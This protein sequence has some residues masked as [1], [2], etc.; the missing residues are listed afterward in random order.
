MDQIKRTSVLIV[1]VVQNIKLQFVFADQLAVKW[2]DLGSDGYHGRGESLQ[3]VDDF[4]KSFQ[5][6]VAVRSPH[7]TKKGQHQRSARE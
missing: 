1:L 3:L 2:L 7:A 4:V 5:L 6:Y